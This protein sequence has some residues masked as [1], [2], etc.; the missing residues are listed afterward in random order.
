MNTPGLDPTN[1]CCCPVVNF[2]TT[3]SPLAKAGRAGIADEV[4]T[5]AQIDGV[6]NHSS[7]LLLQNHHCHQQ[8][9][10]PPGS[11]DALF[12]PQSDLPQMLIIGK[13]QKQRGQVNVVGR[14]LFFLFF[15]S[16]VCCFFR[17]APGIQAMSS[18]YTTAHGIARSL[19]H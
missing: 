2:V 4:Q 8:P 5:L 10:R 3:C 14:L 19:T 17:V 7:P 1:P 18:T 11:L 12:L 9:H 13:T 15:F 16:L 6:L